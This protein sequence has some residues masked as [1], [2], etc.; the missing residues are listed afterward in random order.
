[1]KYKTIVLFLIFTILIGVL[2]GCVGKESKTKE[3]KYCAKCGAVATVS[4]SGAAEDLE[5]YGINLSKCRN[6]SGNIYNAPLCESCCGSI[7]DW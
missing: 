7:A 4:M 5:N 2:S 1:M 3:V 6:V